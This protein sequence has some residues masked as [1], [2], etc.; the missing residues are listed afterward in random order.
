MLLEEVLEKTVAMLVL[1]VN[2]DLV[3]SSLGPHPSPAI[4]AGATVGGLLY[5]FLCLSMVW[6][7][8]IAGIAA[9][10]SLFTSA[11]GFRSVPCPHQ[12]PLAS[13]WGVSG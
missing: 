12:P 1:G 7:D 6:Q 4:V 10:D 2:F 3:I 5:V 8:L 13:P 11:L 9:V